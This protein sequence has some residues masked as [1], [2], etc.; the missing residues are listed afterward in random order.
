MRVSPFDT[1]G[2]PPREARV[3][4]EPG[5]GEADARMRPRDASEDDAGRQEPLASESSVHVDSVYWFGRS[6]WR[7]V[8]VLTS[9]NIGVPGGRPVG[10]RKSVSKL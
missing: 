10:R 8:R 3:A 7:N 9:L 6:S 2:A 1:E 5:D 4:D